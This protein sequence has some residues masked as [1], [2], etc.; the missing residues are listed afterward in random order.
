MSFDAFGVLFFAVCRLTQSRRE[1]ESQ[2]R[3][4]QGTKGPGSELARVL[5]A[6]SLLGANWLGAEKAVNPNRANLCHPP[7]FFTDRMPFLK[8]FSCLILKRDSQYKTRKLS[9]LVLLTLEIAKLSNSVIAF[10]A[11]TLLVGRQVS[12]L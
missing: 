3:M 2:E 9:L 1:R 11:L 7:I 12:G 4:A 6:D 10:S 5:L 8:Q